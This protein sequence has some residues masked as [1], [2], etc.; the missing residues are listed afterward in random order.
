MSLYPS[1]PASD[2][3]DYL[4]KTH[5]WPNFF[6]FP[7]TLSSLWKLRLVWILCPKEIRNRPLYPK[8]KLH[9]EY[10]NG[11]IFYNVCFPYTCLSAPHPS[12]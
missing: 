11:G 10:E 12:I 8:E 1:I 9:W 3:I 4:M 7:S 5:Y 6:F 2:G